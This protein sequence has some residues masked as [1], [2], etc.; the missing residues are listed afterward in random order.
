MR[1][2]HDEVP[3]DDT[4]P[5][6]PL[7]PVPQTTT[8]RACEAVAVEQLADEHVGR[9]AAGVLHE[10]QAGNGARVDGVLVERAHLGAREDGRHGE[11]C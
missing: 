1:A 2:A 11:R 7:L 6:P 3:R 10:H 8:T 4:S 9:P 5:S